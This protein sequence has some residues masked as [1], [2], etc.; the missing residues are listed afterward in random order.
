MQTDWI[1]TVLLPF[2]KRSVKRLTSHKPNVILSALIPLA[3]II[4]GGVALETEDS[5][6]CL[7]LGANK[8][9]SRYSRSQAAF[10]R[11]NAYL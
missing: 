8:I 7:G 5:F 9:E 3:L 4:L 11:L 1:C 10:I 6:K 2:F